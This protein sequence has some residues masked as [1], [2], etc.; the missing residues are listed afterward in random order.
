MTGIIQNRDVFMK[1]IARQ[2][3]RTSKK[4]VKTAAVGVSTTR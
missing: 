2:Y 4:D 3:G 1:N